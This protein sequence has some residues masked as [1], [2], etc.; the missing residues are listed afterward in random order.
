MI[1]STT[2]IAAAAD[3]ER[4]AAELLEVVRAARAGAGHAPAGAGHA[5][6][7]PR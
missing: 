4:T 6:A 3:P 2:A 1:S 7:D 5:P